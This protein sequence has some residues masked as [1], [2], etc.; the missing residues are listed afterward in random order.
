[1]RWYGK[2][3]WR[4]LYT[5]SWTDQWLLWH[6]AF[7]LIFNNKWKW[8]ESVLIILFKLILLLSWLLGIW[9]WIWRSLWIIYRKKLTKRI[10][11]FL[12]DLFEWSF[13]Q[14][15]SFQDSRHWNLVFWK[16]ELINL[17][18]IQIALV[19]FIFGLL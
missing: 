19:S 15:K 18:V 9:F 12:Q 1:M 2:C 6:W 8:G 10:K 5:Q 13:K 14:I 17:L 3:F 11:P 16:I 7:F 4:I